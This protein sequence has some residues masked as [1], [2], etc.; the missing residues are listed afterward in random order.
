VGGVTGSSDGK[1]QKRMRRRERPRFYENRRY[2][3]TALLTL[4]AA[5]LLTNGIIIYLQSPRR[6]KYH[7]YQDGLVAYGRAEYD[8][9]SI[10]FRRF[11]DLE[12]ESPE[13][14]Y[15]L[16]LCHFR[17]ENTGAGLREFRAAVRYDAGF[18]LAHLA[19]AEHH[20]GTGDLRTAAASAM[21][22][23]ATD[24]VPANAWNILA[25]VRVAMGDSEGAIAAF[26]RALALAPDRID[27]ILKLGDLYRA[28]R[29]MGIGDVR[30]G[31]ADGQYRRAL[32]LAT[33]RHRDR[34][35]EIRARVWIANAEA[36]L[37]NFEEAIRQIESVVADRP[38]EAEHPRLLARLQWANGDA[39][40]A[41]ATLGTAFAE[42]PSEGIAMDWARVVNQGGGDR[43]R[44]I[45]ILVGAVKQFPDAPGLRIRLVDLLWRTG[46]TEE[47]FAAM[48]AAR[49]HLPTHSVVV[50]AEG[51]LLVLSDRRPEALDAF[52]SAVELSARNLSARW[53]LIDLLL[54][55]VLSSLAS[56]PA[57]PPEREELDS[58]LAFFLD[59]E[60]GINPS[61]LRA[62]GALARLAFASG[63][64]ARAAELLSG[65]QGMKARSWVGLKIL[66]V[67]S[68]RQADYPAAA[69]A[70]FEALG[71][72]DSPG[73]KADHEMAWMA[74][75][76]A[77]QYA[78]EVDIAE[79]AVERWPD[80][81]GWRL[82]IAESFLR[83]GESDL[84]LAEAGEARRRL[85]GSRDVRAHLLTARIH[86]GR[87]ELA[88]A[89]R[90]LEAAVVIR[91]DP[92]TRGALYA[93]FAATGDRDLARKGFRTLIDEDP[94]DP[95]AFLRFGSFLEAQGDADGART[96]YERAV[97]IDPQ[98][99]RA[100]QHLTELRMARAR[101]EEDAIQAA[102]EG[103][104]AIRRIDPAD[105]RISY[106]TGKLHLLRGEPEKAVP[107]LARF[108][109]ENPGDA[110]GA[111]YL[112]IAYRRSGDLS[113]AR[114][115]F[116]L[117][118][119]LNEDLVEAKLSLATLY[120]AQGLRAHAG[121]DMESARDAFQRVVDFDPSEPTTRW[122]LADTLAQMGLLDLAEEEAV[123]VLKLKPDDPGALFLVS[124][125]RG[126]RGDW[127]A[128]EA[129][130]RRLV[131]VAPD[132]YRSHLYLGMAR[133]ELR[134]FD[135]ARKNLRAAWQREP[136]ARDVLHAIASVEVVAGTPAAAI[137]FVDGELG[138][139]PDAPFLHQLMGDLF[140][141]AGRSDDA[142][143]AY[144]RAF[145]LSPKDT[146]PL[147]MAAAMMADRGDRDEAI[148]ILRAAEARTPSPS[149]LMTLRGRMLFDIGRRGAAEQ[150]FLE[151]LDLDSKAAGAA[152]ELGLLFLDTDRRSKGERWLRRA[153][154]A[155]PDDPA[156][157]FR[158]GFSAAG[159]DRWEDAERAYRRVLDLVPGDPA[160]MN[161]L[162]LVLAN[163]PARRG[164]AI[165][166]AS[167]AAKARPDDARLADTLG[168]VL[169]RAGRH[170]DAAKIL[171][172]TVKKLETVPSAWFH[173]GM[174]CS[175]AFL[176]EEA[177]PMLSKAL[178]LIEGEDPPPEWAREAREALSEME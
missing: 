88:P 108:A 86:Q 46:R 170:E 159:A 71:H 10:L 11:L 153:L 19:L 78:R 139:R 68:L 173:A 15:M 137:R 111:Y 175:R 75:Y 66:G 124:L 107:E 74:A 116:L 30:E 22:A 154:G 59:P 131:E 163:V 29:Y 83:N 14:H 166:V 125:S 145:E 102:R 160:T 105:P 158:L 51:D 130:F 147:A 23:I 63:D 26:R 150:V 65:Q 120:F 9:A 41:A 36:G 39:G 33:A 152:R 146:V 126:R 57:R 161:N 168:W 7:F 49:E 5:L 2:R 67:S 87:G 62:R 118:L 18:D 115:F 25:E 143:A 73:T 109:R 82:R 178:E 99:A 4:L 92:E 151:A 61:D 157:W 134:R 142:I 135:E 24:P 12:P 13:A 37:G 103:L 122:F 104:A 98:F 48:Q 114:Q 95:E 172:V 101:T 31:L 90:A 119:G 21:A 40:T 52:R 53:K 94:T 110:A 96:Q 69:E 144:R 76:R 58:H 6:Q 141:A 8:T 45:E 44:A 81:A 176:W 93:F 132:N 1:R 28:R 97:S 89:R 112:A 148:E 70:L 64:F 149:G 174:A 79:R 27:S 17:A 138:D 60:E 50:E 136:G 47:A 177:R 34:P 32:E 16:G 85:E 100:H 38:G 80:D 35:G 106:F 113:K 3:L 162:A 164:D 20:F 56:G 165:A 167:R 127:D 128:A 133:A 84:A 77:G 123:Q 169:F 42:I 155:H 55:R 72:R 129:G 140:R 43:A 54:P 156:G 117:S 121:G 91:R 171:R